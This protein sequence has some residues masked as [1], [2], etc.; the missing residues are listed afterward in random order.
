MELNL[1][2]I[3]INAFRTVSMT[4]VWM[5]VLN[6]T[7]LIHL[8]DK[9][10][11][12]CLFLVD[13]GSRY[14]Y[15]CMQIL[16]LY[17][18]QLPDGVQLTLSELREMACRQQAQID[19][20]HQLLAAKEQRLRYLKEQEVRQQRVQAESERLKRLRDR[21]DAQELKLRKLRAL[22]G[23]VDHQKQ[24]NISLSKFGL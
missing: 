11:K 23:Q 17:C 1:S 18:F 19:S 2:E 10:S 15:K 24:N 12:R 22:R 21:V 16:I 5:M 13:C 3:S 4:N 14:T 6:R 20:Q 7:T 8:Y 9:I